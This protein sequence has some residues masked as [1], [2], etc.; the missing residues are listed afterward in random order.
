MRRFAVL[1]AACGP[2]ASPRPAPPAVHVKPA[3]LV[4]HD[5]LLARLAAK[6]YTITRLDGDD[7]L[8]TTSWCSAR[9]SRVAPTTAW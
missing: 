2:S 4:S 3:E 5:E 8:A 7:A 6:G 9:R 1:L